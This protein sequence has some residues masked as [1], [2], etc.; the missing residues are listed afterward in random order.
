MEPKQDPILIGYSRGFKPEICSFGFGL[1]F[2][3]GKIKAK[4]EQCSEIP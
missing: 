3:K 1:P 2:G 4:H